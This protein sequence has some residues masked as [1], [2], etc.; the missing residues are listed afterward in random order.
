VT[1]PSGNGSVAVYAGYYDTHHSSNPKPKPNPW[2]GSSN[3]VFDGVPDSPSGGWDSSALRID[4][5]GSTTISGVAVTVD[6]GSR[7]FALWGSHSIPAGSRLILAQTGFENFDGSDTSP[8]GCY[9]CNP[10]DCLTKVS[11]AIP[12]AHVTIGGTT[13]NYY[14]TRQVLNTRGVDGAGCPYTGTRNDESSAWTQITPQ[15]P[16]AFQTIGADSADV[17]YSLPASPRLWLA[18]PYPNPTHGGITVRFATTTSG[19][20]R[21]EVYDVAGRLMRS[22]VDGVLEGGTYN[23]FITLAGEKAGMYY[24]RLTTHEGTLKRTFVLTR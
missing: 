24:C 3:V 4:N 2:Q 12:V 17:T 21:L 9:S 10:N 16:V 13:T 8:A 1:A 18:P 14:D 15:A 11:S 22:S 6:M 7:H 19:P 20:V 23:D 5:L